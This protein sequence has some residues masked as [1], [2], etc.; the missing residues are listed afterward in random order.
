MSV[1][2]DYQMLVERADG[3]GLLDA[4]TPLTGEAVRRLSCDAGIVRVVTRG[5]SEVLDVGRKTRE[6]PRAARRAI[7][8]RHGNRC[9][10]PGCNRRIVQIHHTFHWTDG[11]ITAVDVGVPLCGGHHRLVHDFGW[12]VR[13]DPTTGVTTFTSP[14]GKVLK[15]QPALTHKA[16]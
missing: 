9:C 4:G 1:G 16:A 10:A 12:T 13:Y 5:R 2:V 8:F 11:G 3:F 14:K 6:W 15:T 7:M